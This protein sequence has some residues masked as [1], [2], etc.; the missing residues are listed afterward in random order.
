M[1]KT[2]MT[3]EEKQAAKREREAKRTAEA[4]RKSQ[5]EKGERMKEAWT[6]IQNELVLEGDGWQGD[7]T[8]K[9]AERIDLE[10][11]YAVVS[12]IRSA[13]ELRKDAKRL[14]ERTQREAEEALANFERNAFYTSVP[15]YAADEANRTFV[16]FT[17]AARNAFVLAQ[18]FGVHVVAFATAEDEAKRVLISS[19]SVGPA[20]DDV[21]GRQLWLLRND[22][23]MAGAFTEEWMAW[24][25][26]FALVHGS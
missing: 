16:M 6:R 22:I 1:A 14:I 26:L 4:E 9:L 8:S 10:Q 19:Y 11:A 23:G 3:Y 13:I 21:T 12:Q 25:A 15:L 24:A 18:A 7:I 17:A 2:S 20:V 5:Q